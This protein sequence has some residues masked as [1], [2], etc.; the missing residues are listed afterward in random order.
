VQFFGFSQIG[1]RKHININRFDPLVCPQPIN[2]K[3]ISPNRYIV[4]ATIDIMVA[5][6]RG[7]P[8]GSINR[9][10]AN[11]RRSVAVATTSP[12]TGRRNRR[13]F[14]HL[15]LKQIPNQPTRKVFYW[16]VDN[17]NPYLEKIYL[18]LVTENL[19]SAAEEMG[20]SLDDDDLEWLIEHE[21]RFEKFLPELDTEETGYIAQMKKE[22]ENASDDEI[23][24]MIVQ[25]YHHHP[26][27]SPRY[28]TKLA[29]N[30]HKNYE[31]EL[32]AIWNFC[33]IKGDYMSMLMLLPHPPGSQNCPTLDPNTLAQYVDHKFSDPYS[34]LFVE[35][36][37]RRRVTDIKNR[38]IFCQGTT[39]ACSY[40]QTTYAAIGGVCEKN[41]FGGSYRPICRDCKSNGERGL[42]IPCNQHN[43][44]DD[45]IRKIVWS[46]YTGNPCTSDIIKKKKKTCEEI[47]ERRDY[48]S[49]SR[50]PIYPKDIIH[51]HSILGNMHYDLFELMNY[52]MTLTAINKA[53][54]FDSY[55]KAKF[56]DL[57]NHSESWLSVG[58]WLQ[59]ISHA[60]KEKNDNKKYI[61]DMYFNDTVVEHCQMRHFLT[62]IHCSNLGD[63]Y[64]FPDRAELQKAQNFVPTVEE[65]YYVAKT[66]QSHS[67][68]CTYL[69]NKRMMLPFDERQDVD[70]GPHSP[71]FSFYVWGHFGG[72]QFLR[73]AT[74][75]RH[76]HLPTALG[77]MG[78]AENIKQR[79][80]KNPSQLIANAVE[81]FKPRLHSKD[82][83]NV[84]RVNTWMA[85]RRRV[86]SLREA[87]QIFVE[88][89]CGIPATSADYKNPEAILKKSYQLKLEHDEDIH[90]D[91]LS[92]A[93]TS[94][95]EHLRNQ[96]MCL[97]TAALNKATRAAVNAHVLRTGADVSTTPMDIDGT[98]L[99]TVGG[100]DESPQMLGTGNACDSSRLIVS[101]PIAEQNCPPITGDDTTIGRALVVRPVQLLGIQRPAP[102]LNPEPRYLQ[103]HRSKPGKYETS[104][105]YKAD[106]KNSKT[107][108][109]SKMLVFVRLFNQICQLSEANSAGNDVNARYVVG[110]SL[111]FPK[112]QFSKHINKLFYCFN[113]CHGRCLKQLA[114]TYAEEVKKG[115]NHGEFNKD[116]T[117]CIN[118]AEGK[119]YQLHPRLRENHN[120]QQ[121][122]YEI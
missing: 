65:P 74:E 85:G 88:N 46:W 63:G 101:P 30:T 98:S 20:Y 2:A 97:F 67:A 39:Q 6:S 103:A 40:F 17:R 50:T 73:L 64:L 59:N 14:S 95:P 27:E 60:V 105:Q 23:H 22:H 53:A 29:A 99:V 78:D 70:W 26:S 112:P 89:M 18:P 75:A 3:Q 35:E 7:R 1:H 10:S 69:S 25:R 43:P 119:P 51:F 52:V 48:K 84:R 115:F 54:R 122:L 83:R 114:V 110:S 19:I 44:R 107:D 93:A 16:S 90:T 116:S 71:R 58:D 37:S 45:S 80:E 120:Q 9:F 56:E 36:G 62:Y 113:I 34:P 117:T 42:T 47:S 24:E 121:N 11:S 5:V 66:C 72:G 15:W 49:D 33:A 118:C 106:L 12:D 38:P 104:D 87:A 61:Y 32:H 91:F 57:E 13:N 82:G 76:T 86:S 8:S 109:R 77:Y 94:I 31:Q 108:F 111:V 102:L 68:Y 92:F 4:I 79:L 21:G 100:R 41:L 81:P 28:A 96:T 55:H